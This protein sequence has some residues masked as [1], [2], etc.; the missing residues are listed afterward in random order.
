MV[1]ETDFVSVSL[2]VNDGTGF[3]A[4]I[5]LCIS[6]RYPEVAPDISVNCPAL[7]KS[8]FINFKHDLLTECEILKVNFL[9]FLLRS[10]AFAHLIMFVVGM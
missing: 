6:K 9:T 3:L 5:Q 4:N 10:H 7:T 2:N 1:S 8:E